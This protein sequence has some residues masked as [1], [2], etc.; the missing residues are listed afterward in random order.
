VRAEKHP[1]TPRSGAFRPVLSPTRVVELCCGVAPVAAA[2]LHELTPTHGT[3]GVPLEVHAADID[4]AAVACARTN[5]A[6]RGQVHTGDLYDAL[7]ATLRGRIDVVVAN[8]PYVPSGAVALMPPEARDHEP[9][10]ALDGGVD[11]L[12]VQRRIIAEAPAW[13][14]PGG[15]LLIETSSHQADA[16][17]VACDAAG[18][19]TRMVTDDDL[20][21]TAVV[22]TASV[23]STG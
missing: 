19:V 12:D 23:D 7:P 10:T 13:L 1:L 3:D 15:R 9:R 16:T 5:L 11:G 14:A 20:D 4:P 17:V 22:A 21:A 18:L 6:D 2:I 8:A